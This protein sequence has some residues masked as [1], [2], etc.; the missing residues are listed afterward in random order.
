MRL[1]IAF[2]VFVLLTIVLLI[3]FR[4]VLQKPNV[5][6]RFSNYVE[7]EALQGEVFSG[8]N[9]SLASTLFKKYSAFFESM[10]F[11]KK[12][13]RLL[14]QANLPLRGSEFLVINAGIAVAMALLGLIF[15]KM[16]IIFSIAAGVLGWI[17]PQLFVKRRVTLRMKKFGEQLGDA[18][19]LAA[20]SLRSGCSFAQA[21]DLVAKEMPA[22]ISEEFEQ[23]VKELN[24]GVSVE[25]AF[26]SFSKR[27][28]SEDLDLVITAFLIQRQVGGNLAELLDKISATIKGRTKMRGRIKTLTAQGRL[29]GM[30]IGLLPVFLAGFLFVANPGYMMELF[31]PGPGRM[32]LVAGVIGEIIGT[33]W[34]N[35]IVNIEM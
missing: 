17:I 10:R 34:I 28:E 22:P 11:A 27:I 26:E 35:K 8:G 7:E 33:F 1:L 32:A 24:L 9:L 15:S 19:I 29:S 12:M 21:V 31:N 18:L 13:D 14:Y 6:K 16:N 23:V 25:T 2:Y 3:F 4:V 5:K 20:N 30:I